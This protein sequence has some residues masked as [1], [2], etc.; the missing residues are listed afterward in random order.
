MKNSRVIEY[1]AA[2]ILICSGLPLAADDRAR[3]ELRGYQM[4]L[5]LDLANISKEIKYTVDSARGCFAH[6]R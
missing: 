2:L 5:D 1:L 3:A 6:D 4:I